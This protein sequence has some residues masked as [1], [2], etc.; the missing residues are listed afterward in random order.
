MSRDLNFQK[1]KVPR[2]GISPNMSSNGVGG[3]GH[4]WGVL[5]GL[6]CM[7]YL[8]LSGMDPPFSSR[9]FQQLLTILL[10]SKSLLS[11]VTYL[12]QVVLYL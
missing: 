9:D 1:K 3:E 2:E 8:L 11:T 10:N 4:N 6:I 7:T 12:Y 5:G